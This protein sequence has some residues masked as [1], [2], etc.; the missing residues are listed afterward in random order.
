[1][2]LAKL[3]CYFSV[4]YIRPNLRS[5]FGNHIQLERFKKIIC[6]SEIFGSRGG[7]IQILT[8]IGVRKCQFLAKSENWSNAYAYCSNKS[9]VNNEC[10][11]SIQFELSSNY[12]YNK[13][14]TIPYFINLISDRANFA[15]SGSTSLQLLYII[16]WF[17][18]LGTPFVWPMFRSSDKDF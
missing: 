15:V 5:N 8:L 13:N 18:L 16:P 11:V 17:S 7:G 1:M 14:W 12:L 3:V 6:I 9:I 10:L 4:I 2:K